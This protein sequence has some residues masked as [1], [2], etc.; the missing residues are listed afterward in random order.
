MDTHGLKIT[1]TDHLGHS[2]P[3]HS[4][5]PRKWSHPGLL[6]GRS[7]AID[8]KQLQALPHFLDLNPDPIGIRRSLFGS[9][10]TDNVRN[11][12][13]VMP[14]PSSRPF[15]KGT[16][17]IP[18]GTRRSETIVS[19]NSMQFNL[20]PFERPDQRVVDEIRHVPPHRSHLI[21]ERFITGLI[22]TAT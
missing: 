7:S 4:T 16:G 10:K 13:E 15:K 19:I 11:R 20:F 6:F 9:H 1:C 22:I 12:A 2:S 18:L 8:N 5:L 17:K 14:H 3:I 21:G